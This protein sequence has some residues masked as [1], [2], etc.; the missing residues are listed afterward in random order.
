MTDFLDHLVDRTLGL[1]QP[2][3]RN[4]PVVVPAAEPDPLVEA[5]RPSTS[6]PAESGGTPPA[7]TV[8]REQAVPRPATAGQAVEREPAGTEPGSPALPVAGAESEPVPP[9]GSAV[10]DRRAGR[11]A[12]WPLP[13]RVAEPARQSTLR[14]PRTATATHAEPERPASRPPGAGD[15]Q[16]GTPGPVPADVVAGVSGVAAEPAPAGAPVAPEVQETT[17]TEQ[18][19][20]TDAPVPPASAVAPVATREFAAPARTRLPA[21]APVAPNVT[22]TIGTVVVRPAATTTAAPAPARARRAP[23]RSMSLEDYLSGREGK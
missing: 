11:D 7:A 18:S 15:D 1:S 9:A 5:E 22:V 3:R 19:P 21:P 10:P 17:V 16:R 13:G 8:I 23:T 12:A 2:L 20:V 6:R 4:A 14:P